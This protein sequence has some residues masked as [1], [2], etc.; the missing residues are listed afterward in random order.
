MAQNIG[1]KIGIQGEGEFQK[2][3]KDINASLKTMG[4]EMGKVT[5]AF[6]GQEKSEQQLA[7]QNEVLNRRMDALSQ[8]ADLQRQ[9][10]EELRADGVD[11]TSQ[12][13]QQLLGD[14]YK[15]ETQ[16][17]K[18]EAEIKENQSAMDNLGK[19]TAETGDEMKTAGEK[20]STFGD[21]LKA[22]LLSEAIIGGMKAL[23]DGAKKLGE[24]ILGAA[25]AADEMATLSKQTGI[26]TSDLQKFQ[27][28][29][30]SI[31]VPLETL[32]G[33]M[34][35]LTRT[36]DSAR[37]G[38]S[39]A[40]AAF[41]ALGIEVTNQDGTLRD[42]NE[43][44][45]E[46]I[47]ALGKVEDATN[48]DAMAMDIF[49]KSAQDLNPLILGGADALAE[50]GAH[51]EEAGLI[52]S[53][54]MLGNLAGVNDSVD[55]LKQTAS[56]AGQQFLAGFAAPISEAVDKV[57]GYV[58]KLLAAFKTG[59][60]AE[61]GK[62][63]GEIATEVMQ[64]LTD[65]LPGLAEFAVTAVLTLAEGLLNSLPSIVD[66]ALALVQ[67]LL[68][69]L[70]E[71]LPD[72]IPVAVDAVLT[73]VRSLTDPDTLTNLI[74]AALV[75]I[76]ALVDGITDALPEIVAAA[77]EIIY[78]LVKGIINALPQILEAAGQI[79]LSLLKGIGNAFAALFNAGKD[80]V[81]R[82]WD[83]IK[84]SFRSMVEIGGQLI[85]GLWQGIKN[86]G[87][88]IWEQIK[89]FFNGIVGGIKSFLGIKSPSR[90]FAG[91]GKNMALG[92]GD[93]FTSAMATV[94][95]D[96]MGAIPTSVPAM[97]GAVGMGAVNYGGGVAGAGQIVIPVSVDGVELVRVLYPRFID[98]GGRRGEAMVS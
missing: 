54:D 35:K 60:M 4:A 52:L 61:L 55:R 45:T 37:D 34:T 13:Y 16:M 97:T 31:D 59:G 15:T 84:A 51:A 49:G 68:T 22:N 28:A 32:T 46:A 96:M 12:K 11:P 75:L 21:V 58:E 57:T 10:L 88:W 38:S 73:I 67:T 6:A 39:K 48:R 94:E 82:I 92:L 80:V 69:T 26:A 71:Q 90:V 78:N 30:E 74:D 63:V 18:T 81:K 14:L 86:M 66:S 85:K 19:E 23:A 29:S 33:S 2:Q 83:G 79:I 98:E 25:K 72:L 27:Y 9:R 87:A 1:P 5:S 47:N 42:R 8:K 20:S 62:T 65:M 56:L 93:G 77:P 64:Q 36:M 91:I 7:A 41:A 53:D 3:I 44:F 89:G 95:R 76:L 43:V 17:N 40:Q 50:L 70:T 24:A